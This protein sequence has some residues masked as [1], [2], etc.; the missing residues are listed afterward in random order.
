MADA[1]SPSS[2][3]P[4][5]G[6]RPVRATVRKAVKPVMKTAPTAFDP[7]AVD[8]KEMLAP[9]RVTDGDGFRLKDYPTEDHRDAFDFDA[10]QSRAM[11]DWGVRDLK[12][13]QERLYATNTWSLLI[14]FQATDAAGKDST[15]EHVMSGVNPQG[16]QVHSFKRPSEEELDHDFLWRTVKAL[17]ERGR[18]GI[19]NRSYYEEVLVVRVHPQILDKQR[20]PEACRSDDIFDL[21]LKDIRRHERFLAR[22]GTRILKF[23]L[24]LSKEEQ[25]K[26]L[27]ARIEDPHKNWKFELGDLAERARWDDY[28]HA[29][30]EAIRATASKVAPWYV[31]PADDKKFARVAV[32]A[33]IRRELKKLDLAFPT[34]DAKT[35]AGLAAAKAQLDAEGQE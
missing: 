10:E 30:E 13:Q 20:L 18:I 29:Y 12:E 33:A 21:R 32:M 34:I 2:S 4:P 14:I 19:F 28:Q 8:I 22:Q 11:L 24:H 26:R 15:I 3:A 9:Y 5:P 23:F 17:P 25:R 6:K 35:K 16:C 27:L 31:I 1:N 7:K